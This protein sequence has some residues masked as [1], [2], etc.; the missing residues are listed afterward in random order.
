MVEAP[1]S[2]PDMV[3][4]ELA[5]GL[6]EGEERAAALRRVLADPDFARE[7][8]EWRDRFAGLFDGYAAVPAPPAIARRLVGEERPPSR[9][10]LA[11]GLAALA[12]AIVLALV[13][14][15][16]PAPV[17]PSRL[18]VASLLTTDGKAALPAAIDAATGEVRLAAAA[19][20]PA[21]KAAQLWLIGQDGV[22][23]SMGLLAA[24]GPSRIRLPSDARRR[25]SAD[26]TLAVSIEPAG[27]SPTGRPTGPV[28]ASGKLSF[29]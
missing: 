17:A 12:A 22:P 19:M 15:P 27:G 26:A 4:A 7:V 28:V 13:L 2:D 3:A 10:P 11:A 6:L 21:G 29:T 14:R 23:R 18:L 24:S 20:A 9:W 8:A 1:H 25:L 16:T 5:L